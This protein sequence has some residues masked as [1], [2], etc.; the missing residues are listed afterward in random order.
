MSVPGTT[1]QQDAVL[2]A[3][4]FLDALNERDPDALAALVTDDVRI[5]TSDD[6][7]RR[8]TD[9]AR[10]LLDAAGD[11]RLRLIPLHREEHAED[12]DGGVWV[13][14]RVREVTEEHDVPRIADFFVRDGDIASFA[15]RPAPFEPGL[16]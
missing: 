6:R 5:R 9:G 3:Y 8:G 4:Q 14:L 15:L 2:S 12:R 16:A 11:T 10:E 7:V 13:E 1:R